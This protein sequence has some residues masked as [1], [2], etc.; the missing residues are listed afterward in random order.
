[1]ISKIERGESDPSAALL[2]R[3]ADAMAV[4]MSSLMSDP[5]EARPQ[6]LRVAAQASWVD[7][8]TGYVRRQVWPTRHAG[9]V[10]VVAVE[11]PPGRTAAFTASH[12]VRAQEQVLLMQGRLVIDAGAERFELAPGD[13]ALVPTHEPH[14]FGNPGAEPCRYL[15]MR[16][17]VG[18]PAVGPGH[19]GP[20][21]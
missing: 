3:L 17:E 8:S 7:P 21:G 16:L 20:E 11:L 14:A 19:A 9:E 1:M 18:A 13:C 15:V 5:P 4:S 6:V 12:Q 2:A 10:E